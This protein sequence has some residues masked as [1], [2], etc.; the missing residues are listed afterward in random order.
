[1]NMS[2]YKGLWEP[3]AGNPSGEGLW[4]A[5]RRDVYYAQGRGA[6]GPVGEG[7]RLCLAGD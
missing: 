6:A 2:K 1:M 3:A 4:A 5:S 7:I